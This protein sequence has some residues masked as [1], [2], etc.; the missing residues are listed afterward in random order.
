MGAPVVKQIDRVLWNPGRETFD[1]IVVH[2]CSIHVEQMTET[3]YW[4][5][6]YKADR[7]SLHVN[8]SHRGRVPLLAT[9]WDDSDPA[10]PWTW[11]DDSEHLGK[12]SKL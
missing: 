9:L 4:M 8:L 11:G 3:A 12:L 2:N 6:V 10:T 1:E 5:G 7:Q